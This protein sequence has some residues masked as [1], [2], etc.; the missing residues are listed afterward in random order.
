MGY[1]TFTRDA[2]WSMA[3]LG[4]GGYMFF[5]FYFLKSFVLL[6]IFYFIYFLMKKNQSKK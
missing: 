5:N 2:L 6:C 4:H 3:L 1:H